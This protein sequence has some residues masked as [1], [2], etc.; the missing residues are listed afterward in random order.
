M[1]PLWSLRL[2]FALLC[3][4]AFIAF[5][6]LTALQSL[7]L[8]SLRETRHHGAVASEN[9]I[10]TQIGVSLLKAGG[11]AADAVRDPFGIHLE[12]ASALTD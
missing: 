5:V 12:A 1:I 2:E 9:K 8:A 6:Y 7:T 10:C 4:S 11:N 3:L